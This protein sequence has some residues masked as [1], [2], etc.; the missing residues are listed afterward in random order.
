M[1][2]V[3]GGLVAAGLALSFYGSSVITGGLEQETGTVGGGA[4]PVSVSA[5]LGPERGG[6][7]VYVVQAMDES[8][9][10]GVRARIV[11]PMG[12]EL[13]SARVEGASHEGYFDIGAGGAYTLYVDGTGAGQTDV[14]A[15][16]GAL[17]ETEKLAVGVT[18]FYLIVAG[19]VGMGAV[20]VIAVRSR[21]RRRPPG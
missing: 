8:A 4:A 15:V 5:D 12:G 19:L 18:G 20:G 16:I 2:A 14:I 10:A 13:A 6:E 7:G 11:G 1:L 3:V 21:A 9:G 17:P